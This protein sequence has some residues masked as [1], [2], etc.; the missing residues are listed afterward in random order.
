MTHLQGCI[1]TISA[2]MA[3]IMEDRVVDAL[4]VHLPDRSSAD[5]ERAGHDI[6]ALARTLQILRRREEAALG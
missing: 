4:A 5:L 1:E 6:A 3:E 2:T